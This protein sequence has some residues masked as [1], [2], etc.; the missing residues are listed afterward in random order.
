MAKKKR[1]KS[2]QT[3]IQKQRL[4]D[5]QRTK[6]FYKKLDEMAAIMGVENFTAK[7]PTF[8]KRLIHQSRVQPFR[9]VKG[10]TNH[11]KPHQIKEATKELK[12]LLHNEFVEPIDNRG[13]ISLYDFFSHFQTVKHFFRTIK[14]SHF[15]EAK[16]M[17]RKTHD[18]I[19]KLKT[20]IEFHKNWKT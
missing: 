10:E 6:E 13:K 14:D 12:L 11:L 1:K 9:V 18:A 7:I 8:E 5:V 15:P 17:K 3:G 16:E 19:E 4:L 2:K 20:T